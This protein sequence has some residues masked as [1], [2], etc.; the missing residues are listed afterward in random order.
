LEGFTKSI[1]REVNPKW[2]I[3]FLILSPGAVKTSFSSN[4]KYQPRH[5]AYA[6]D[7][8]SPLDQLLKYVSNSANGERWASPEVCAAVLFDAIVS[9]NERP[10]PRRLNLGFETLPIMRADIKDYLKEMD[11]WE[12]ET[13]IVSPS[14]SDR[15]DL[16]KALKR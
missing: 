12:K 11:E 7:P 14:Q 15:S 3:K 13:L 6:N 10:L 2:N 16:L 1:A 5:P 4:I 9:Q 8:S